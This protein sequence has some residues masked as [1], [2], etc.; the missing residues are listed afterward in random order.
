[1]DNLETEEWRDI[2]GHEGY[3][4]SNLG[5]IRSVRVLAAR[6]SPITGYR[7]IA[8]G[9]KNQQYVHVLVAAAFL[10]PKPLGFE[11]NHIDG[12]GQ[13]C[14]PDNLEYM[15]REGNIK[16]SFRIGNRLRLFTDED[17]EKIEDMYVERGMNPTDIARKLTLE[18]YSEDAMKAIRGR[19]YSVLRTWKADIYTARKKPKGSH[20]DAEAISTMRKLYRNGEMTQRQLAKAYSCSTGSVSRIINNLVWKHGESMRGKKSRGNPN[21]GTMINQMKADRLA[22]G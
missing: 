3:Q 19:I 12:M 8:A 16:H 15:T 18:P 6:P 2:P 22:S 10:G 17:I 4:A 9:R 11:V 14:R 20:L 7:R 5:R 13:N 1:M 21:F